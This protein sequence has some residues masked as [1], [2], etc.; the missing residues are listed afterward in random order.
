M[1]VGLLQGGP[2]GSAKV[3]AAVLLLV[4]GMPVALVP[5]LRASGA[6]LAGLG[7]ISSFL[8]GRRMQRDPRRSARSMAAL[9]A[10][11]LLFLTAAGQLAVLRGDAAS[12]DRGRHGAASGAVYSIVSPRVISPDPQAPANRALRAQRLG[13][14]LPEGMIGAWS[15]PQPSSQ[16]QASPSGPAPSEVVL[17]A[18]CQ[19]A[20]QLLGSRCTNGQLPASAAQGLA[21]A[22]RLP[23]ARVSLSTQLPAAEGQTLFAVGPRGDGFDA[24]VRGAVRRHLAGSSVSGGEHTQGTIESPLTRWILAGIGAGMFITLVSVAIGAIDRYVRGL[25]DYLGLALVGLSRQRLTRVETVQFLV[26][27]AATAGLGLLLGLAGEYAV[28]HL[29]RTPAQSVP[30]PLAATFWLSALAIAGGVAGGAFVAL[31]GWATIKTQLSTQRA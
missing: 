31:F 17:V 5:V 1:S 26:S 16:A 4:A 7:P 3:F 13:A 19:K 18:E 23:V 21:G 29:A 11:L 20:A 12:E 27:Y 8:A 24:R 30:F 10:A 22:L 25:G 28:V 15:E 2:G 14:S 9:G 6:L